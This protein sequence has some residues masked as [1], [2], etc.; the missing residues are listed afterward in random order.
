MS[1][2][3]SLHC[4]KEMGA[5]SIRTGPA[6]SQ[7]DQKGGGG[8]AEAYRDKAAGAQSGAAKPDLQGRFQCHMMGSSKNLDAGDTL[9]KQPGHKICWDKYKCIWRHQLEH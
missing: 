9:E 4:P 3:S 5:S 6:R 2:L 8:G 1:T 7:G